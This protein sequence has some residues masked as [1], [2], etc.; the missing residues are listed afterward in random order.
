VAGAL[1]S[2]A[3]R[4]AAVVLAAGCSARFG[5]DKRLAELHGKPLID[6]ALDALDGFVFAQKIVVVRSD[7]SAEDIVGRPGVTSVVNPRAA[8]GMGTSLACGIAALSDVDGVFI[9]L[10]D[11]PDVPPGLYAELAARF[12]AGDGDIVV[13]RHDGRDGHPVLFGAACFAELMAL[14]GDRGGRKLIDAGRY[15]VVRIDIGDAGILRDIDRPS[16]LKA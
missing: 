10:A 5:G 9:V 13:P 8:E 7:D 14:E 16:D 3:L 2:G 4:L 6:H 12:A 15:R 1:K 11:M